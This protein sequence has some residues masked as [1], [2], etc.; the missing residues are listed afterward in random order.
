[1]ELINKINQLHKTWE[2]VTGQVVNLRAT[3]RIWYEFASM[4]FTEDDLR[5]VLSDLMRFNRTS[6]G[7]KFRINLQKICGDP[8]TFASLLGEARVKERNRKKPPTAREQVLQSLRP[9]VGEPL[10]GQNTR[11]L[12]EVF[13]TIAK[14]QIKS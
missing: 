13:Q 1:M 4:D 2:S 9:T 12:S 14:P 6:S 3:E 7:A 10:S 8:E 5:C 11:T